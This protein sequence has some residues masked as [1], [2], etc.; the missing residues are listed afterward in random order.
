MTYKNEQLLR[1]FCLTVLGSKLFSFPILFKLRT[2]VYRRLFN[3][4]D[5]VILEHGVWI[6]RTH[7]LK[8]SIKIGN[9]VLLARHVA[10]D[11]SGAIEIEDDV[12][13][14]EGAQ[15]HSH[16]HTLGPERLKRSKGSVVPAHLVLRRGCWIG[17][18]AIIL[19][20]VAEVGE[21]AIVAAGAVVTKR[22]PPN[23][24]VG[25]NPARIIKMLP[26]QN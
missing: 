26:P 4:G 15:L 19:P 17:A 7:G 21:N 11:Y 3:I 14:S 23:A 2:Y 22:V 6:Q 25:G 12:W 1:R 13:L 10:I 18:H 5:S 16:I 20:Q 8:G 24:V 9:R